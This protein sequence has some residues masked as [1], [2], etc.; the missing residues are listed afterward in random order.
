MRVLGQQRGIDAL[1][2]VQLSLHQARLSL[3]LGGVLEELRI[4]ALQLGDFEAQHLSRTNRYTPILQVHRMNNLRYPGIHALYLH[5]TIVVRGQDPL[6]VVIR[7]QEA[8]LC[9]LLGLLDFLLQCLH[10]AQLLHA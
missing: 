10:M 9:P 7:G 4:G 2:L 5:V 8:H 6:I 1:M 3:D